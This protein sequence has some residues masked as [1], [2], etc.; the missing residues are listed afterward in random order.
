LVGEALHVIVSGY[1]QGVGFRY[2]TRTE[3][4]RLGLRGWVRNR[5]DGTVEAWFEGPRS[6]LEA[7]LAW[8]RTGPRWASVTGVQQAWSTGEARHESFEIR[9]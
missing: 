9:G 8:C 5:A 7:A 3:A 2:A 4:L 6:A 1:V